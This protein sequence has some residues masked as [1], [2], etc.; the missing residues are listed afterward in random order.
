MIDIKG[1]TLPIYGKS[2]QG[3]Y[4]F[5]V[6]KA[7][8]NEATLHGVDGLTLDVII[9]TVTDQPRIIIATPMA[10][11]NSYDHPDAVIITKDEWD[12]KAK[13]IMDKLITY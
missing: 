4:F 1:M 6:R 11:G 8:G 12:N 2:Y 10:Y 5:R 3:T 9:L 13:M 7:N